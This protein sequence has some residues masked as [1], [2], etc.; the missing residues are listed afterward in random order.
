MGQLDTVV[1]G[2]I[3]GTAPGGMMDAPLHTRSSSS[4]AHAVHP[5][6]GLIASV[7]VGSGTRQL[8]SRPLLHSPC[9]SPHVSSPE[10]QS[11]ESSPHDLTTARWGAQHAQPG[12]QTDPTGTVRNSNPTRPADAAR[13]P[14]E[15]SLDPPQ[16]VKEF[17]TETSRDV[18][19]APL[20]DN[21]FEW[22][23]AIRGA[24]DTEYEVIP[25]P[26]LLGGVACR[27][28]ADPRMRVTWLTQGKGNP[29][30]FPISRFGSE[31]SAMRMSCYV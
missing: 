17:Y 31:G 20:E 9:V 22:Q 3:T 7:C 16:E 19:S 1:L 30:G 24:A 8:V 25:L 15:P 11:P 28:T 18:V 2:G 6:R 10:S 12:C 21:I 13:T 14:L 23:F 29:P 4:T 5:R 27:W 26:A